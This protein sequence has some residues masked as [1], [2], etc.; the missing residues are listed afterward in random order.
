M[1]PVSDD[2]SSKPQP[3]A[4]VQ[5]GSIKFSEQTKLPVC[6]PCRMN[7][8]R[9]PFPVWVKL[10]AGV[11]ALLVLVS[12]ALS[13]ERLQ[14]AQKLVLT[15]R[16]VEQGRWEEAYQNYHGLKDTI[17]SDTEAMLD[18]AEAASNSGHLGDAA[19]AMQTLAGRKV[20][21]SL[22]LRSQVLI[23][24]L[25]SQARAQQPLQMQ[26]PQPSQQFRLTPLNSTPIRL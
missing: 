7:L 10:A 9:F 20:T 11:V 17:Q 1:A 18:Y 6:E 12:L 16:M 19:L 14:G 2:E 24:K 15:R 25:E 3:T 4:C 26:P 8:V 22:Q 13:R 23:N 21:Q 5:C